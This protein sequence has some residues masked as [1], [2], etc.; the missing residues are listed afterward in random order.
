MGVHTGVR[1]SDIGGMV[2]C[3]RFL[4]WGALWRAP[5]RYGDDMAFSFFIPPEIEVSERFSRTATVADEHVYQVERLIH[6]N[7]LIL[8]AETCE[9]MLRIL[10]RG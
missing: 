3:K 6:A 7:A 5:L 10:G 9:R 4:R 8:C 2:P 1:I